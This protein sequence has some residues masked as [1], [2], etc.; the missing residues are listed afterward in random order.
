MHFLAFQPFINHE[1]IG[2]TVKAGTV[3]WGTSLPE[4]ERKGEQI[5]IAGVL[6]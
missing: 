1:K 3:R 5:L 2:A 6:S 4:L